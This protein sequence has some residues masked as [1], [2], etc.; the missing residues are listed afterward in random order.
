MEGRVGLRRGVDA[1]VETVDA[2]QASGATHVAI[3]SMGLGAI[4]IDRH[5]AALAEVAHALGLPA[6]R[7]S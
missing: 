1:A 3:N 6:K 4:S 5:I 7:V 2:W